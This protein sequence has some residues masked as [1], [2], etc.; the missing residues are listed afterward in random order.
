M[1]AQRVELS[2]R[3]ASPLAAA[4]R[5]PPILRR[6][7]TADRRRTARHL[8]GMFHAVRH[9]TALCHRPTALRH[10]PTALRHRP[11]AR[12]LRH[13]ARALR[14][15]ALRHP[16]TAHPHRPT[17]RSP[18]LRVA[19]VAPSANA[20]LL[21]TIPRSKLCAYEQPRTGS[22]RLTTMAKWPIYRRRKASRVHVCI[23][24][25]LHKT[26]HIKI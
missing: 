14:H 11:T 19:I 7:L 3:A 2:W 24:K 20:P 21:A 6:T 18:L 15:T 4:L 23:F 16:R 5:L 26:L 8:R 13:T 9:L 1:P 22:R 10:R 12:A 25:H 17:A